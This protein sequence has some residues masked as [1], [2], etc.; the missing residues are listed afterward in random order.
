MSQQAPTIQIQV[1]DHRELGEIKGLANPPV[2]I[3]SVCRMALTLLYGSEK[4]EASWAECKQALA[5]PRA[6]VQTMQQVSGFDI[7][8][9]DPYLIQLLI[10]MIDEARVTEENTKNNSAAAW[11]LFRWVAQIV[12]SQS[13]ALNE[14]I[15]LLEVR[16][17]IAENQSLMD[18]IAE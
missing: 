2:L 15:T 9:K 14:K 11:A 8:G 18:A 6:L 1:P 3:L 10:Q 4:Q 5:N 17:R 12:Q 16:E 13:V 7:S